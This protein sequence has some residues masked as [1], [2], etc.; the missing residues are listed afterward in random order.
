MTQTR[1]SPGIP[2][3]F[4]ESTEDTEENGT[5]KP[6]VAYL[7]VRLKAGRVLVMLSPG[8]RFFDI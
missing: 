1:T 6:Q 4:T 8:G 7:S 5:K 3:R 2:E